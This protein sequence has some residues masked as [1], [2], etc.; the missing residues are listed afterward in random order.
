MTATNSRRLGGAGSCLGV[1]LLAT[2]LHSTASAEN[3]A[4]TIILAEVDSII[5]PVSAEF[6]I[7]TIDRAE[8]DHAALVVFTLRT[9]GGLVDSTRA[10]VTR[11]LAAPMPIVIFVGPSR[12]RAASA[13]F[14]LTIAADIA[15]MAPGTH[16]G[17]AHPVSGEGEK[18]DETMSNKA[19]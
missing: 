2:A 5:Q 4:G 14:I 6:M 15:A 13:A 12:A 3:A 11:M 9:P 18:M 7:G 10:I 16:I 1:C 19:A 17:A 8:A